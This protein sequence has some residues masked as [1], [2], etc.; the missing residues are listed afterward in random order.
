MKR[1]ILLVSILAVGVSAIPAIGDPTP[2]GASGIIAGRVRDGFQPTDGKIFVLVIGNDAREGNPDNARAD[3]LHI[4][5][6]NAQTLKGGILNFPRDSYVA[7]AGGGT[8]RINEA[9]VQGGPEAVARTMENLTGIKI[10]M[11]VMTGFVGFRGLIED[12]GKITMKIPEAIYDPQGSGAEL[13]KG[14]YPLG[15]INALAFVRTRKTI[16]GG[17]IGRTTNQGRFMLGMLAEFRKETAQRPGAAFR[18][19]AAL[20]KHTRLDIDPSELFRL[21]ILASKVAP[22][23]VGNVTVP[24]SLG[25]VGAASVVFIQGGARSIYARFKRT[26]SL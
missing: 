26:A 2:V 21:G 17:D 5:G 18:W 1:L 13:R 16:A 6:I 20:E 23:D 19:I 3:A 25:Q 24:V 11:W 22:S 7:L 8:G 15:P 9:L 4:V 10:D 12:V 14:T